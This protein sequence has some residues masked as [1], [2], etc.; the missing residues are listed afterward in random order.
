MTEYAYSRNDD[1][2]SWLT[3]TSTISSS[4]A[5]AGVDMVLL[6]V[7]VVLLGPFSRP[8]PT[9]DPRHARVGSLATRWKN[10]ERANVAPRC[11]V[12]RRLL[13]RPRIDRPQV[14]DRRRDRHVPLRA[15]GDD[16]R[17]ARGAPSHDRARAHADA[18]HPRAY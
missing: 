15:R 1:S 18:P 14:R 17:R 9:R 6:F 13:P 7:G 3:S 4:G 10:G 12:H 16:L 8:A 2:I 11:R 5:S